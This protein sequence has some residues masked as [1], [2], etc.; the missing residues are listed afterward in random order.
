MHRKTRPLSKWKI[1]TGTKESFI[2]WAFIANK[3]VEDKHIEATLFHLLHA[4][5]KKTTV[6]VSMATRGFKPI[7]SLDIIAM[8]EQLCMYI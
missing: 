4:A 5:L 1:K 7:K 3:H 2:I 6:Y 8:S